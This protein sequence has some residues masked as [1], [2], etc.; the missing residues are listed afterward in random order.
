MSLILAVPVAIV[1]G[2]SRAARMGI[3][4][5]GGGALEALGRGR[6]LLFD[7]TG[8][9]TMGVP[10]VADVEVLGSVDSDE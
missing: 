6:I 3:I 8:T 2:V 1:A 10:R 5:K 7:K 4:V 9:L